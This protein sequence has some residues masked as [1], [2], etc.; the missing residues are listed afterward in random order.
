MA[1]VAAVDAL[2]FSPHI[3]A[4]GDAAIRNALDAIEYAN[5]VNGAR[6]RRATIAHTQLVD[7]ADLPR[8]AELG[9]IANFEPYWAKFDAWQ[10][11]LTVPRL[12]PERIDRQ[13]MM[14]TILATGAPISFGSDWPVTTYAPLEGIQVA[15]TRQMTEGDFLDPWMPEERLTVEES[16]AAY[17][18]GVAYQA[19]EDRSGTLRPGARADVVLLS[20]D[21]RT[22]AP[23]EI[24]AVDVLGTWSD[25]VRVFGD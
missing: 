18:S 8:F 25:G 23:L 14:R 20:A 1:A 16:L 15:V 24:A 12:G 6:D 2:G 17:T 4:I 22:V 3:H 19:G 5:A 11:E 13:F 10:T 7:A 21:P 9:V